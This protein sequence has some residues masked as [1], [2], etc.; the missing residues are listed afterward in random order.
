MTRFGLAIK[1]EIEIT[2]TVPLQVYTVFNH[3]TI[4]DI[5]IHWEG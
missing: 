2:Y 4:P 3:V 5:A 1:S